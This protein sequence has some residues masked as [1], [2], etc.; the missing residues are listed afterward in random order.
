MIYDVNNNSHAGPCIGYRTHLS[1]D[2]QCLDSSR[3]YG[4][5]RIA[6]GNPRP[7]GFDIDDR[8]FCAALGGVNTFIEDRSK[9][10]TDVT[11]HWKA[12]PAAV[13]PKADAKLVLVELTADDMDAMVEQNDLRQSVAL[14]SGLI[15][16]YSKLDAP[17]SE[18][19]LVRHDATEG[20]I[21]AGTTMKDIHG[22][23]RLD[24]PPFIQNFPA[25]RVNG[26][27]TFKKKQTTYV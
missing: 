7:F 10:A 5:A 15:C 8:A 22:V 9:P 6:A 21:A 20:H 14:F 27:I 3:V 2:F 16:G 23:S 1:P 26:K 24:A 17:V 4:Q 25:Q 19:T 18:M 11:D 12:Y 13:R